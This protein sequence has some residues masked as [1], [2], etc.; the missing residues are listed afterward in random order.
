MGEES[1][2]KKKIWVKSESDWILNSC[3]YVLKEGIYCE[4]RGSSACIEKIFKRGKWCTY[5]VMK[6]VI[7]R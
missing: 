6:V 5:C 7:F 1:K 2:K 3:D 4:K